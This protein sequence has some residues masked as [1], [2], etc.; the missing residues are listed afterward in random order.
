MV[1]DLCKNYKVILL[2]NSSVGKTSIMN[3]FS[4]KHQDVSPTIGAEFCLMKSSKYNHKLQIWDCA[5]Q[6]RYRA[7][8]RIYYRNIQGCVLIFD[9]NNKKSLYDIRD[10]W[11]KEVENNNM[12]NPIFILVGNKSDLRINTDYDV[13]RSLVNTYSMKYIETSVIKNENICEI[14]NFMSDYLSTDSLP[15]YEHNNILD[16]KKN[17]TYIDSITAYC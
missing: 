4:K 11:V 9:L 17:T 7:V 15:E 6:E 3:N 1:V 10:Y 5:G 14:F 8:T 16:T 12:I 13:I 2:G